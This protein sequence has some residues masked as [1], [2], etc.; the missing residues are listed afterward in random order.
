MNF[1]YV[2]N[3]NTKFPY[4]NKLHMLRGNLSTKLERFFCTINIYICSCCEINE[5]V[6]FALNINENMK[7][8]Y[9]NK[10]HMLKGNLSA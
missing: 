8:A 6:K 5:N 10:L 7:F 2:A 3:M 1:A 9:D 4:D